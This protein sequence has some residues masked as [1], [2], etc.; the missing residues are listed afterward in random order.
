MHQLWTVSPLHRIDWELRRW[1]RFYA[2]LTEN[3]DFWGVDPLTYTRAGT[4][5]VTQRGGART[6]AANVPP[7]EF[8]GE[9]PLGINITSG[10][11]LQFNAANALDDANTLIWFED[12]VPK[13]TPSNGNPFGSGGA[14]AG[15]LTH[16]KHV[17][18]ASRALTPAEINVIQ[19]RLEDVVQE[20]PD[21][22]IAPGG[23]GAPIVETP[24]HLGGGVYETSQDVDLATLIVVA[25][26]GL[27]L[28]RVDASPGNLQF[29]A[30][31][32]GNRTITPGLAPSPVNDIFVNYFIGAE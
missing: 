24:T 22:P 17:V 14:W 27:T 13:S 1:L 30:S 26:G 2:P 28:K 20:I 8:D 10:A 23:L 18:K 15:N 3:L 11:T 12:G 4:L 6:I 9:M 19:D 21:F 29:T 16:V 32:T 7:F 25:H 31:G 5:G